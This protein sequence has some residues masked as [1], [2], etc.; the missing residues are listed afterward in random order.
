M[1]IVK[2]PSITLVSKKELRMGWSH[3]EAIFSVFFVQS[4]FENK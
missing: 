2:A 4:G 3:A 1:Y